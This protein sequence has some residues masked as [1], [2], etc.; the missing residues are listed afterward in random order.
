VELS[1]RDA[2]YFAE[3]GWDVWLYL[4][5]R[6]AYVVYTKRKPGDAAWLWK[7]ALQ[8]G[9]VVNAVVFATGYS[10]GAQ[11]TLLQDF[12]CEIGSEWWPCIVGVSAPDGWTDLMPFYC[13]ALAENG[14]RPW[15]VHRSRVFAVPAGTTTRLQQLRDRLRLVLN[16]AHRGETESETQHAVRCAERLRRMIQEEEQRDA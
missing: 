8:F 3:A 13:P 5:E 6:L 9:H 12:R 15:K 10:E 7:T 4:Q 11:T 1:R 16:Q 14:S 2:H